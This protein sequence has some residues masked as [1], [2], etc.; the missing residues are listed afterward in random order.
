MSWFVFERCREGRTMTELEEFPLLEAALKYAIHDLMLL[1]RANSQAS[2][3]V[4]EV[5][6]GAVEWL[7]ELR[8]DAQGRPAWTSDRLQERAGEADWESAG[9]C[10]PSPRWSA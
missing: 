9:L 2:I 1:T 8:L 6:D 5:R 10:E 4:G 7:G 3:G